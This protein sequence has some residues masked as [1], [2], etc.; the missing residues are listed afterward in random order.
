MTAPDPG[1]PRYEPPPSVGKLLVWALVFVFAAVVVVLGG[2]YF[3]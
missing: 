1:P 2:I 3:A